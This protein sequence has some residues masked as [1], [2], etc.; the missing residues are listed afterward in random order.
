MYM[1][2]TCFHD[3]IKKCKQFNNEQYNFKIIESFDDEHSFA[4]NISRIFWY[5]AKMFVTQRP[6][7]L[8]TDWRALLINEVN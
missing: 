8:F 6:V 7:F 2:C 3:S 1:F 4:V 5:A